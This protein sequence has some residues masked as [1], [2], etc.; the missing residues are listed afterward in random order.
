MNMPRF[1][2]E[3]SLGPSMN[4]YRGRASYSES[5][6]MQ[7]TPSQTWRGFEIFPLMRC[8]G[9]VTSLGR[10]VSTS[11]QTH[12]LQNC[13]CR[14]TFDGYPWILCHDPVLASG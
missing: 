1:N 14:R 8:C 5:G 3:A 6:A 11:R 13:E 2:A 7:V 4:T 10:F 12:P 9:Y